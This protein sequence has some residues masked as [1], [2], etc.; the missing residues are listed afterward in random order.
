MSG[1]IHS[2]PHTLSWRDAQ[3]RIKHRDNFN[4]TFIITS[5]AT[6]L[7]G[8]TMLSCFTSRRAMRAAMDLF[9]VV[10]SQLHSPEYQQ[11]ELKFLIYQQHEGHYI[12]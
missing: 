11:P 5:P 1:A 3:L 8:A 10:S 7:L 6:V 9:V 12:Q 2:L 4:F